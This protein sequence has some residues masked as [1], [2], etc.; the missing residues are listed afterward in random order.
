[1]FSF[2]HAPS[3][4]SLLGLCLLGLL[5]PVRTSSILLSGGTVIPF[6][7]STKGLQVLRNYYVLVVDD[8]IQSIFADPSNITVP[9]GT[10]NVDI[11]GMIL[12][13]GFIDTHAHGWQ[14]AFRTIASNT[15]LPEY[16]YR[17]GEFASPGLYTPE[18]VYIEQLAGLLEK[19]NAGTTTVLDHA[20]GVWSDE[21][22]EAGFNGS[23]DSGSRI[24]H[25]KTIHQLTNGYTIDDQ[26]SELLR[27]PEDPRLENSTVSLGLSYDGFCTATPD[28]V[29]S[30]IAAA[31][32]AIFCTIDS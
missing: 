24:F 16:F 2:S 3:N 28:V 4:Q 17:Y 23:F 10:E 14:T 25:V 15:S 21:T 18:D 9:D 6:D 8:R 22:S 19:L 27:M 7:Q 20:H 26:I 13:P 1:M 32:Y 29:N 5:Q 30:V 11:T 31:W 12:S